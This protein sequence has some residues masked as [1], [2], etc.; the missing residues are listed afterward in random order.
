M[1]KVLIYGMAVL[2]IIFLLPFICDA[3]SAQV[4][5]K[6]VFSLDTTFFYYLDID[7]RYDPDGN[8]EDIAADYNAELNSGVFDDL[9]VLDP[10]VGGTASIG[11]SVVDF[12][13][14]YRT[15]ELIF[16]YGLTDKF[17]VG[18]LVDY[19][20][21]KRKVGARLDTSSANVGKSVAG[22]TLAPLDPNMGVEP[23]T[24]EDVQDLLGNGLDINGDGTPEIEGYGYDRVETWSES[25]ICDIELIGKYMFLENKKWRLAF[26]GGF[27]LPTGDSDN[28]D[29]LV[30]VGF[31]DGQTDILF[32]LHTDFVGVKKFLFNTTIRYDLQLP[33]KEELRV[34][35]DVNLPLTGNK[36]KVDRDLGDIM[37]F[38]IMGN[39]SFT[40]Q[41]SGGLKYRFTKKFKDDIDGNRGYNY[42]SLEDETDSASHIFFITLGYSTVQQYLN[43]TFPVPLS[44]AITYRNRFAGKNNVYKARYFS[45]NFAVYF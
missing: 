26:S 15:F 5:P 20:H 10:F 37:E 40:K 8:T 13:L 30:D 11:H 34:S 33:D 45:L 44:A 21:I 28:P 4:L 36:E 35:E 42:T 22:N 23:L 14:V 19:T 7:Q 43:K 39:Y 16:S 6:G 12:T 27:R 32:R 1:K 29:S 18:L 2:V 41:F 31:G 25:G 24:T 17:S 38:E 3:D 9:S